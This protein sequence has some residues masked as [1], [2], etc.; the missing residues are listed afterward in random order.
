[1]AQTKLSFD[2]TRSFFFTLEFLFKI[3]SM[4]LQQEIFSQCVRT[5][6]KRHSL[7]GI[8]WW[9]GTVVASVDLKSPSVDIEGVKVHNKV[10]QQMVEKDVLPWL[11]S[12][13]ESHYVFIDGQFG[14]KEFPWISLLIFNSI[15]PWHKTYDLCDM[16]HIEQYLV[17]VMPKVCQAWKKILEQFE[18][19]GDEEDD[20]EGMHFFWEEFKGEYKE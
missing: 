19:R 6:F 10:Y 8:I 11:L 12:T 15:K 2:R 18:R 5:H 1:M 4:S 17:F 14:A 13:F 7:T 3:G 9:R 20:K 16:T